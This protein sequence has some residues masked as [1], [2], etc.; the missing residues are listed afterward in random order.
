MDPQPGQSEKMQEALKALGTMMEK[1]APHFAG[2]GGN[3]VVS[4]A[5]VGQQI[6]PIQYDPSGTL[7][8][9]PQPQAQPQRGVSQQ[10][11][12]LMSHLNPEGAATFS[13]IQGVSQF[14][15]EWNQRKEQKTQAE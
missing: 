11:D 4:E 6:G 3:P 14:L 9:M 7:G 12:A 15:Q 10:S 5:R 1:A 8:Q 2:G 13:A